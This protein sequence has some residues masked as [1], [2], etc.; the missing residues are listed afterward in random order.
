[1]KKQKELLDID[2]YII[3]RDDESYL[4]ELD[5]KYRIRE[6]N[7]QKEFNPARKKKLTRKANS[8]GNNP[9]QA[10]TLFWLDKNEIEVARKAANLKPVKTLIK[11]CLSCGAKFASEGAHNRVC[12][13]C[14]KENGF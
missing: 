11:H 12:D 4:Q 1:M 2:N 10:N 6:R 9:T 5:T 13:D 7:I 14:R 3:D 8:L